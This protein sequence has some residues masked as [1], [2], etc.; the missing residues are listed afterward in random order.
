MPTSDRLGGLGL[1]ARVRVRTS[2]RVM[3]RVRVRLWAR[4]RVRTSVRVMVRVRVRP[5]VTALEQ[6]RSK[7][8]SSSVGN[9]WTAG[10]AHGVITR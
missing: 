3:V 4:V 2:V 6:P 9:A 10:G 1:G 8:P 7:P 5:P